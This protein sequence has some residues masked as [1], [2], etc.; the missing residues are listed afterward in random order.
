MIDAIIA[1]LDPPSRPRHRRR[2][3]SLAVLGVWAVWRDAGRRDP[4]PVR[5]PGDR[6]HRLAGPR[7]ARGRGP[8]HL[9]ARRSACRGSA[10][11]GSVRSSSDFG[12]SMISVIFDDAVDVRRGPP[13]GGRAAGAGPGR[14]CPPGVDAE[15]GARLRRRPARS[16]G[17]RSRGAGSTWAGSGRSRTGTS[18]RS[19]ASVAGRGRGRER[20]RLPDRVPG[21]A[22]T[23]TGCGLV[24][25]TLDGRRRRRR[26][27]RTRRSAGTSIQK[28]NAEYV[29]RGVG[30]LGASRRARRR[31]FD[32]RRSSATWRTSSC[33]G[34]AAARS[35]WPTWPTV[36]IGPGFRRGV[37]EKDGNEVDRRRGPDGPRREPAR[38]HPADQGQDPRARSRAC[39]RASRIVPFYDRTPLIEGAIGTVTRHGRRGD[40]SAS[41]CVLVV[42][43][44]VRTSF[45]I[46][47]TLP[48]A[49][50]GVVR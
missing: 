18:G 1:L 41:V 14:A 34:R 35:G 17:T 9:S 50:L 44:H 30:W 38:G 26:A 11:C 48:L 20:R 22:S 43:L 15:L 5:E 32:P 27:R 7:P 10:G 29:V 25:V 2:A 21:R 4:R 8:G 23:P 49:A 13:A 36:A 31:S 42:L 28:G 47:V 46:A 12:F 16:S 40:V 6:L 19:S 3:W 33:R 37:L 39:R 45:V 24:G